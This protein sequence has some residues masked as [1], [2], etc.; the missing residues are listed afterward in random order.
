MY[1]YLTS[2]ALQHSND[3]TASSVTI[4]VDERGSCILLNVWLVVWVMEWL[5]LLLLLQHL[6]G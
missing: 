2:N 6:I 3:V 5:L 4:A 1:S